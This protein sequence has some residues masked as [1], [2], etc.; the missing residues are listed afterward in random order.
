VLQ[1]LPQE[2]QLAVGFELGEVR[3]CALPPTRHLVG[4]HGAAITAL[5]PM[6]DGT[7]VSGC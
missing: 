7:L 6:P 2:E 4:A 3:T 1:P 5:A